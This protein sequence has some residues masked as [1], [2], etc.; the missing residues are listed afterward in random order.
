[1][2]RGRSPLQITLL[3]LVH[4]TSCAIIF[5]SVGFGAGALLR[6]RLQGPPPGR[7]SLS[8]VGADPAN[9]RMWRDWPTSP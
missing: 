6:T 5:L 8:A 1:M 4:V 7:N 3:G 9:T 2:M